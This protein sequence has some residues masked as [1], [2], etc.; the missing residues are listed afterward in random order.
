MSCL[1]RSRESDVLIARHD[2]SAFRASSG[3][4]VASTGFFTRGV[5]PPGIQAMS[6]EDPESTMKRSGLLVRISAASPLGPVGGRKG[7]FLS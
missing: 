1:R 5:R 7:M 4:K 3:L 2:G 6:G